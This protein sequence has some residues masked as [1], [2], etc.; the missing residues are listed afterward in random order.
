MS[1]TFNKPIQVVSSRHWLRC[2][3]R[4][5]VFLSDTTNIH[6]YVIR[7]RGQTNGIVAVRPENLRLF[8]HWIKYKYKQINKY[9]PMSDLWFTIFF[10]CIP[11]F[12]KFNSRFYRFRSCIFENPFLSGTYVI[13]AIYM[14]NFSPIRSVVWVVSWQISQSRFLFFIFKK[15]NT[16]QMFWFESFYN[17]R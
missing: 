10:P 9:Y 1:H 5:D 14:P 12:Y 7:A 17:E 3:H 13:I 2:S 4:I 11:V 8:V 16:T 6:S 15:T